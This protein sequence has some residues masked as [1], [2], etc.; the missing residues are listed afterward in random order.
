[1]AQILAASQAPWRAL[2]H[3]DPRGFC[4]SAT[5]ALWTQFL[6]SDAATATSG[7]GLCQRAAAGQIR[8][9]RLWWVANAVLKE[10]HPHRVVRLTVSGARAMITFR[11]RTVTLRQDDGGRHGGGGSREE[12][13]TIAVPTKALVAADLVLGGDRLWRVAAVTS[14]QLPQTAIS[15]AGKPVPGFS[16]TFY[17]YF[18][19][20]NRNGSAFAGYT[21]DTSPERSRL[22]FVAQLFELSDALQAAESPRPRTSRSTRSQRGR[23]ATTPTR[24]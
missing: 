18:S 22:D 5:P 14:T 11:G 8:S 23:T 13:L 19:Q 1:M 15:S 24:R 17:A 21:G 20:T 7:P 3:R 4:A 12:M 2:A 16:E 6:Q 10:Q 9:G